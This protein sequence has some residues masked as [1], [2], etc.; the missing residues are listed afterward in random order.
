MSIGGGW[1]PDAGQELLLAAAVGPESRAAAAFA[2]WRRTHDINTLDAGSTR[3][4]PLLVPRAHLFDAGNAAWPVIRGCYRR[5]F[6]HGQMVSRS[7][8]DAIA[9]LVA[10]RIPVLTLKGGALLAYYDHNCA[11]RPMN[12]FDALVPRA[13]AEAAIRILLGAGWHSPWHDPESLP[14]AYHGACFTSVDGLDFDLHWQP[15]AAAGDSDEAPIWDASVETSVPGGTLRAPCAADLL[16]IVCAHAA[17]W[18]PLPPVRWVADALKIIGGE[19]A[20]F[21]WSRVVSRAQAWRVTLP[22]HDTLDYLAQRWAVDVPASALRA[23]AETPVHRIDRH[24]YAVLGRM[25]TILD[26]ILRPW[27][28]YR[29]RSVGVPAWKSLPGFMRYL[30]ITLGLRGW[31]QLPREI[32]DRIAHFRRDRR[33]GLR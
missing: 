15:L 21:D 33:S 1:R 28:R 14:Y 8:I 18:S 32:V 6:V 4:L 3:L 5:A 29:L 20:Q 24:A 7:A 27:E 19:G 25:P 31:R 16:T 11:L 12:D 2:Q 23:L 30:R 13:S 9:Q 10:A 17:P 22:L 26:Y